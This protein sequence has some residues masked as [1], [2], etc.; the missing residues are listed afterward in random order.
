MLDR[1]VTSPPFPPSPH[2]HRDIYRQ[3]FAFHQSCYNLCSALVQKVCS[4]TYMSLNLRLPGYKADEHASKRLFCQNQFH[5]ERL[6]LTC[7]TRDCG[8]RNPLQAQKL[9]RIDGMLSY[10]ASQFCVECIAM[11]QV[12]LLRQ[13]IL[14]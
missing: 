2:T 13:S 5:R 4:P 1:N 14:Y 6:L 12:H 3:E 8:H 7:S 11:V 10:M 9:G